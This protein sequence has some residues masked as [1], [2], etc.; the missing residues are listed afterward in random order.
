MCALK[1][2]R[3]LALGMIDY[4]ECLNKMQ[5]FTAQRHE[6]TDDEIWIVEHPPVYTL[7]LAGNYC[8]LLKPSKNIPL[9][10]SDRGGQITYHG[11]GQVIVYLLIDL[12]RRHLFVKQYVWHIEQAVINCLQEFKIIGE[13]KIKAPGVY[14]AKSH[15]LEKGSNTYYGCKIAALGLKVTRG[16]SYHG[17]SLNVNM[18]LKPFDNINPCG[19]P[20]LKTIDMAT[21]GVHCSYDDVAK[22][23]VSNIISELKK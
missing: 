19:M 21:L 20:N 22:K 15:Y 12:R 9:V 11:P 17:I 13:R 5:T 4:L 18:N 8:H 7:G 6:E 2:P 10:N 16:C 23:L 1:D 14:I 3:I